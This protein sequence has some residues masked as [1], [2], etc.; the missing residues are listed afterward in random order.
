MNNLE[1]ENAVDSYS[2]LFARAKK[3]IKKA[4]IGQDAIID[5]LQR[6]LICNGHV[7]VEGVPGVGKTLV[8]TVLAETIKDVVF[9]RIQ[10]TPD[11]LPTDITGVTIY[12]EKKGEFFI[13]KG[14]VF[15]NI[16]IGD[17][18]NRTPPKVQSSML[19]AMQERQVTIG[20]ETFDLPKPFFVMAT[21][22]PVE[23]KGVYPLPEAQV[24]R[25]LFKAVISYPSKE[26]EVD[27]VENNADNKKMEDYG[28]ER[29]MTLNDI[30]EVQRIVKEVSGL[31]RLKE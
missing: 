19:Q 30:L 14:P 16:V 12:D 2:K 9:Q 10:F 11:L 18:I 26:Y 3:E 15:G 24:D 8:V 22:N 20:K 5:T 13:V 25:F 29:V 28:I 4:I 6:A 1:L 7:L 27:I 23:T 21:Q 31:E 17:E